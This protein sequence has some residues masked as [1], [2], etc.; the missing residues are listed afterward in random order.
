MRQILRNSLRQRNGMFPGIRTPL[1]Q[2][3]RL[4]LPCPR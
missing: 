3:Q 4:R 1:S 2:K